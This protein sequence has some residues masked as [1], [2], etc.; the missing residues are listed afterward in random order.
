MWKNFCSAM[1]RMFNFSGREK[2]SVFWST[3]LFTIAILILGLGIIG[4]TIWMQKVFHKTFSIGDTN[5]VIYEQGF[6]ALLGLIFYFPLVSCG[7]RRLHD[8]NASGFL[9]LV[10]VVNLILLCLPSTAK[11]VEESKGFRYGFGQFLVLLFFIAATGF[12]SVVMVGKIKGNLVINFGNKNQQVEKS[13]AEEMPQKDDSIIEEKNTDSEIGRTNDIEKNST[14]LMDAGAVIIPILDNRKFNYIKTGFETLPDGKVATQYKHIQTLRIDYLTNTNIYDTFD[15]PIVIGSVALGDEYTV[16]S[17]IQ[18]TN[19]LT[20]DNVGEFWIEV[21]YGEGSGFIYAGRIDNPYRNDNYVPLEQI[22]IGEKIWTV[23]KFDSMF[24][25]YHKIDIR[26]HPGLEG[27]KV[28]GSIEG[29]ISNIITVTSDAITEQ[30]DTGFG[31]TAGNPWIRVEYDGV[32]GWIPG[33][34]AD[35]EHGGI[36]FQTPDGILL[37][38]LGIGI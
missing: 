26:N 30:D 27:T 15:S 34:Y 21:I 5:L 11:D 32:K 14:D 4:L 38:D 36:K 22:Q 7:V 10:P 13:T 25:F 24:S 37:N 17:L 8:I 2:R 12:A 35:I 28:I 18:L 19:P 23:R 33:A 9:L 1:D 29:S 31:P 16:L 6:F 20:N 3:V